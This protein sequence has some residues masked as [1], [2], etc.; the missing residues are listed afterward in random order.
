[1]EV[2]FVFSRGDPYKMLTGAL[3]KRGCTKDGR[4]P[5][6]GRGKDTRDERNTQ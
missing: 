3:R 5:Y 4:F 2:Y 6:D 1:M